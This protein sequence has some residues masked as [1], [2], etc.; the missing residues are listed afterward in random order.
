MDRRDV[1]K[2]IARRIKGCTVADVQVV[3]E[4]YAD[5]MKDVLEKDHN[6]TFALP[7]IGKFYVKEIPAKEGT[8]NFNGEKYEKPAHNELKFSPIKRVKNID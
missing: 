4:T 1:C 5:V 3:L 8:C 6:E 7:D 2:L